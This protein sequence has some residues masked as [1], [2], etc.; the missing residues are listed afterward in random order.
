VDSFIASCAAVRD[1]LITDGVPR[2]KI[3]IVHEGVDVDRLAHLPAANVHAEFY[4]PTGAPIVMNVAA[5]A[6]HKGQHHL[7]DAAALVVREVPDVRFVIVGSGELREALEKHV[8]DKHLERHVLIAGFR[9]DALELTKGCD[10]FAVSSINDGLCMA[11][12][13][14]MAMGKPAVATAAGGIPEVMIDGETGYMVPPRDHRAMADRIVFL[15]KH[16]EAR[17]AMGQAALA[18]VRSEFTVD[19]MVDETAAVY[20]RQA[21]TRPARDTESPSAR[22]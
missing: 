3:T 21:G 10:V 17:H 9:A 2:T 19:R 22:A 11:L 14:A 5:L 1:R 4:L 12:I 15:L 8:K 16:A 20:D 13:D 18:R 6:P 7:I